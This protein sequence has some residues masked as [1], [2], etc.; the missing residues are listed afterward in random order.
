[1]QDRE[2]LVDDLFAAASDVE[3]S[4]RAEFFAARRKSAEHNSLLTEGVFDEVAALLNANDRAEAKGF[5]QQSLI[6]D[7]D[8]QAN[9]FIGQP[10][11]GYTILSLIAAG[12]MGEVYLARDEE[13]NFDVAVKIVRSGSF[14]RESLIR[15]FHAERRI[16][17]QL[18]H[19]NIAKIFKGGATKDGLPYLVMEYVDG[20]SILQYADEHK[21]S[22]NARLELFRKVCAAVTYAHQHLVIHRDIKPSNVLVTTEGEP[23]LLDFGIAKLLDPAQ[24]A[25]ETVTGVRAM[26]PEYASPEQIRGETVTTATDVYSLGV[27]LYE[28]LTGHRPYRLKNGRPDEVAQVICSQQPERPSVAVCRVK[29]SMLED[30]TPLIT[31][32]PESVSEKCDGAPEHLR[33]SLRGDIDNI[34]LMALRKEPERRYASV[35]QFSED[36]R[37]HLEG[38][39]VRARKATFSY[40]SVKF[41]KRNKLGVAIAALVLM[42]L[43]GGIIATTMQRNRAEGQRLRAERGE[44]SN[45]QLL[46]AARMSLAYQAWETANVGRALELLEAQKPA[47]GEADL[48]GFEWRL[49]WRVTHDESR[50][51]SGSSDAIWSVEFSPDGS[52]VVAAG[53]DEKVRVWNMA[54]KQLL[55]VFDAQAGKISR[56]AFSPNGKYLAAGYANGSALLW[57][58]ETGQLVKTLNGHTDAISSLAFSPDGRTLATASADHTLKLWRTETG[59]AIATLKGHTDYVSSVAFS[60]D[61]KTLATGSQDHTAKLWNAVS[62][63]EIVTLK[64]HSW[65][66]LTVA[67]APDGRTLAT[68]GS[69]G[70]INLWDVA[71]H[72]EK[73]TI[74]GAGITINDLRF[75]P[76][77]KLLAVASYDNTVKLYDVANLQLHDILRGHTDVIGAVAFSPDGKTLASGS[78]DRTVRLWNLTKQPGEVVLNGH[79]DWVWNIAFSPDGQTLASASKDATVKLWN[80][81]TGGEMMTLNHPQWVNGV[82]FSHD[83]TKLASASDDTFVRVWNPRTGQ[84]VFTWSENNAIAECVAFSTDDKMLAAGS[85][86][87]D[88]R[89]WD[90]VAGKEISTFHSQYNNLIWSLAFSPDGKYLVTAEG[91]MNA[92]GIAT[93]HIVTVWDVSAGRIVATLWGHTAD[94]RAVAFAPDGKTFVTGSEDRTIKFWDFATRQETATL[95][96]D[97]I[98]SLGFSSDGKRL[99]SGS[100]NKAVKIWDVATRQELCT[101]TV[102]SVIN[103]VAF[104]PDNKVLAAASHDNKIRLWFAANEEDAGRGAVELPQVAGSN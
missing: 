22:T 76:N 56:V 42:T 8:E 73:G 68:S 16:L 49:L 94:V 21:L 87:G 72:H 20:Q 70:E 91:G 55:R 95:K 102:P 37:R 67:F 28:L 47:A 79:K 89:I 48:R 40:R 50:V 81:A 63:K 44:H 52:K 32:T 83:G 6:E 9:A 43:L 1:M 4:S 54:S 71:S 74:S 31:L 103:S 58:A 2:D 61:G 62:G 69:D 39:P 100:P 34:V 33:R 88:I 14:G 41:L 15:R 7:E 66:V 90:T 26:T 30:R 97:K 19:P 25:N 92:L 18:K 57:E 10:L 96:S 46:Y 82:A 78:T 12:G 93:G 29:D 17:A 24:T 23:K 75:S 60:P 36:I 59:E 64:G 104:S 65:W 51:L 13:L 99:V 5:L 80:V 98:I 3:A 45:R 11:D 84:N 27:L 101:L 77:G 86:K 38:L 53:W 35:E 85:K